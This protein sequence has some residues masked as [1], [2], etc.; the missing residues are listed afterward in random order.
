MNLRTARIGI[1]TEVVKV[2]VIVYH[3]GNK[4]ELIKLLLPTSDLWVSLFLRGL[5]ATSP[6]GQRGSR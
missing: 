5:L 1:R 6:Q 2:T 3:S 4:G